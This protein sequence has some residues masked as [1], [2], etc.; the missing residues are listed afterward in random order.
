[1]KKIISTIL[2][3]GMVSSI[4]CT[5]FANEFQDQPVSAAFGKPNCRFQLKNLDNS[6]NE[7]SKCN[8]FIPTIKEAIDLMKKN[9]GLTLTSNATIKI[10]ERGTL[11]ANIMEKMSVVGAYAPVL[12]KIFLV[13]N[14]SEI[15]AHEITHA[16]LCNRLKTCKKNSLLFPYKHSISFEEGI[17]SQ[18]N[19]E[20]YNSDEYKP[21]LIFA[22]VSQGYGALYAVNR[23]L[24]SN[25]K[26]KYGENVIE[27]M[28]DAVNRENIL[29]EEYFLQK[30]G[31]QI[32]LDLYG[33][34]GLKYAKRNIRLL[35]ILSL[36]EYAL[37]SLLA[38]TIY[39][40]IRADG[41]FN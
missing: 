16:E 32:I 13:G 8:S 21:K 12:D 11:G 9:T 26:E 4:S 2:I 39:T 17:A 20:F 35:K 24:I 23:D 29:P 15:F 19:P 1:M 25:W 5:S 28:I 6:L 41:K 40:E 33:K 36:S 31:E 18:N 30:G 3:L 10:Y 7:N 27:D 38:L 22:P 37:I 34:K 14:E